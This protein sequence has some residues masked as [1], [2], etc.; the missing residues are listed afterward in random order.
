[1]RAEPKVNSNKVP[2]WWLNFFLKRT[3]RAADCIKKQKYTQNGQNN[4]WKKITTTTKGA[5]NLKVPSNHPP[6]HI[7]RVRFKPSNFGWGCFPSRISA[8]P[9]PAATICLLHVRLATSF[10]P[11]PVSRPGAVHHVASPLGCLTNCF[12]GLAWLSALVP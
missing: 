1:M 3:R 7:L 2:I 4:K 6:T 5:S 10:P 8:E 12:D 9:H 11:P